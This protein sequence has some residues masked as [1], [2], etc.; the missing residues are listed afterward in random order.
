[1]TGS[2]QTKNGKF[3][4]VL[5]G[6][7]NGKRKQYWKS[8]GLT[9]K[10]NKRKAEQMLYDMLSAAEQKAASP[11][12]DMSVSDCV[13]LWL[14]KIQRRVDEVTYQ[15]YELTARLHVLPYFDANGLRLCDCTID[16]L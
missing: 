14:E 5:N 3:Y 7:E 13:R 12:S 10:G 15:G 16:A 8:T 4:M 2:L 1:M 11:R 6:T 9:V